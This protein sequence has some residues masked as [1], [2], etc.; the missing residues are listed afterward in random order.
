MTR[1][2]FKYFTKESFLLLYKS[3][4]Q[5]HLEY[6]IPCWSPFLDKDI[7]LLEEIQHHATKLVSDVSSLAYT[8]HL[9]CPGLYSMHCWRQRGDLIEA[10]T[11]INNLSDSRLTFPVMSGAR[12]RGR[13]T[14]K[15]FVNYS[16]LKLRKYFYE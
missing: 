12:T 11:I 1:K 8:G 4:F 15:I 9:R 3:L 6:C 10:F 5:P 14:K 16:R 13:H 7:D 2:S